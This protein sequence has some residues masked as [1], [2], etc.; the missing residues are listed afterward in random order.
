MK[1]PVRLLVAF[2]ISCAPSA[3]GF[4]FDQRS[5]L[6]LRVPKDNAGKEF[7]SVTTLQAIV[8]EVDGLPFPAAFTRVRSTR[9][10]QGRC[11]PA[12]PLGRVD[13]WRNGARRVIVARAPSGAR[14]AAV[15]AAN[16]SHVL[17]FRGMRTRSRSKIA[18]R[19]RLR[20]R[21]TCAQQRT[22]GCQDG[23]QSF[24]G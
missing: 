1:L 10:G 23:H 12:G 19:H 22:T 6:L 7:S 3:S 5:L 24:H 14:P 13:A 17:D 8:E 2:R 18:H 16:V 4:D 21:E 20:R 11:I 9:T 15:G